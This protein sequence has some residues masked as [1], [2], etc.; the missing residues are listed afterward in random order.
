MFQKVFLFFMLFLSLYAMAQEHS[1]FQNFITVKGDRLYDGQKEFR[2]ISFNIP[3]LLTIED[4][5]PFAEKNPWR[6]PD[7]YEIQDALC[8][9]Q[10]M[11]GSVT[12]SYVIT[13]RRDDDGPEIPRFVLGPGEFDEKCFQAMDKVLAIANRVGIRLLV[14]FV[15]NWKWMGGKPQY[16]HFRNKQ[17]REFFYDKTIKEDFK[18]T[19]KY[20]LNRKNTITGICYKDDKSILAWELGNELRDAP[21]E[22]V[23]EMA[24]FIKSQDTNHLV[25]DGIQYENIQ[26]HLLENPYVDILS[27]HHYEQSPED[28]IRHIQENAAKSKGKKPFYVGEFGFISTKAMKA[29]LDCVIEEPAICGAL[30][31]SL[32]FHNRDGG[33]YWHTEPCG[34]RLYKAYHFP[35]FCSGNSYD[36]HNVIE[37]FMEKA[38]QIQKRKPE[39][40]KKAKAPTLLPIHDVAH[41]SWQGSV[42]AQYYLVERAMSLEGIWQVV[43]NRI[44]DARLSHGPLF[45]DESAEIGK[46]Y[47]YRVKA[48]NYR[49]YSEPSNVVGPVFVKHLTLCDE[50]ENYGQMYL[51]EGNISFKT[52]FCR[53]FKED[54]HRI[55][56]EEKASIVYHVPGAIRSFIIF[57]F[58]QT[59]KDLFSIS[60]SQNGKE[61]HPVKTQ[62]INYFP[63]GKDYD[64]WLPIA[65]QNDKIEGHWTYIKIHFYHSAQIGRIEIQ[66]R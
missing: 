54:M 13:V 62:R 45:S 36:E 52:D 58:S 59:D 37:L 29:L 34:N 28:M 49:G 42:G 33:F 19:I 1:V 14:P 23:T 2:F 24:R 40:L 60:L 41:I 9:I 11:G 53:S 6:L 16:A 63:E 15:D 30:V 26:D 3:N 12:R 35:G 5:V 44:S 61:Y 4:N 7:E 22:W 65:F 46:S 31:W 64:Y 20:I 55:A 39:G 27:S 56:G 8:S 17:E 43:G 57:S 32:R 25:N 18:T 47:F 48:W 51:W 21:A 38:S 10:E 50:L 66:F